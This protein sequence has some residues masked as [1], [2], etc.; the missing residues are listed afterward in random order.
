MCPCKIRWCPSKNNVESL[1]QI[2]NKSTGTSYVP[3][4]KVCVRPL[5]AYG[6]YED[7]DLST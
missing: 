3:E 4:L 6:Q 2:G 7:G 1:G 5:H